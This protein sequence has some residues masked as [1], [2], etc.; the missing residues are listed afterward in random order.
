M[1]IKELEKEVDKRTKELGIAIKD[2]AEQV[3]ILSVKI[4]DHICT[5]DAHNPG[6]M[7]SKK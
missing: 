3:A 5:P 6:M 7:R 2:L 1:I 4:S